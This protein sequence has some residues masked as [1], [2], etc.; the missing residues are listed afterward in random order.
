MPRSDEDFELAKRSRT[1]PIPRVVYKYVTSDVARLV[2]SNRKLLFR[3]PLTFNDPFDCQWDQF[4]PLYTAES[5]EF[6]HQTIVAAIKDP[7]SCPVGTSTQMK[8][9]FQALNDDWRKLDSSKQEEWLSKIVRESSWKQRVVGEDELARQ[10]RLRV[11]CFSETQNSVLMWSHYADSHGGMVLGFDANALEDFYKRPLQQ[12][13]Y[14][15]EPPR[16]FDF[17]EFVN[18]HL[19]DL[20]ESVDVR[21]WSESWV[22]T[23]HREWAYER[24]WRFVVISETDAT[25]DHDFFNFPID[26]IV[27]VTVGDRTSPG[28][29]ARVRALCHAIGLRVP[30]R[31]VRRDPANFRLETLP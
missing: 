19:F 22:L 11:L 3:S 27:S 18:A 21:S 15:D 2:L 1:D 29:A 31:Q 16:L 28:N 9:V 25:A 30:I 17:R 5:R 24:E 8:S 23:K 13:R 10:R 12:V 4:W 7:G 20:P 6:E 26:A 14:M